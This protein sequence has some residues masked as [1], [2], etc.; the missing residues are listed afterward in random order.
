MGSVHPAT[1]F[2]VLATC[3]IRTLFLHYMPIWSLTH[4]GSLRISSRSRM[5]HPTTILSLS[6][7]MDRISAQY[8]GSDVHRT[9]GRI[10]VLSD[11]RCHT[12]AAYY[13]SRLLGQQLS[14]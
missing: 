13:P 10:F 4:M 8:R 2:G 7:Q 3:V 14:I 1:V 9:F 6:E 5:Y 11:G 12:H